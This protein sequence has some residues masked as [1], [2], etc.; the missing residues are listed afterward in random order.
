[1]MRWLLVSSQHHP[2]QGGVGTYVSRFVRAATQAGWHVELVTRPGAEHPA[3]A[4]VHEID[5]AD[6]HPEFQGRVPALRAIERIRPYRYGLWSLE[7]ARALLSV[8]GRFDAIE[9]VDVQAEG[10]V[11][12]TSARVRERWSGTPMIVHAHTPMFVEERINGADESRFGRRIYHAWER[13]ALRRADGVIVTSTILAHELDARQRVAVIPY[14]VQS[15]GPPSH[16]SASEPVILFVGTLQP[17]KGIASWTAS[18]NKV[19]STLPDLRAEAIGPDTPTGPGGSSMAAYVTSLLGENVRPRFTWRGR[20]P[21]EATIGAIERA[22]LVVAPSLFESFSFAAAEALDRGS[23]V[24]V[25]DRVG[26][27]EH[28]PGLLTCPAGNAPELA[29]RQIDILENLSDA[30]RRA[31]QCRAAMLDACSPQRHLELRTRFLASIQA[32]S[33]PAATAPGVDAIDAMTSFL[34]DVEASELEAVASS[35]GS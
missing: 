21:H 27:V 30:C 23:P 8:R 33:R 20:L 24:L 25:S 35:V 19:L 31:A 9:F 10:L 15:E 12:L 28:V 5:T 7:V 22:S 18:L 6:A 11:S 14:P 17:R 3:C 2:S 4:R 34:A 32:A 26:L 13:D 29:K 16:D 1:M